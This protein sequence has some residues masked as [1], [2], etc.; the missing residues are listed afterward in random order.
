MGDLRVRGA[1]RMALAVFMKLAACNVKRALKYWGQQANN[2]VATGAMG[3]TARCSVCD[4]IDAVGAIANGTMPVMMLSRS[5]QSYQY[6]AAC[7]G[8]CCGE[9]FMRSIA[10]N[11][12]DSL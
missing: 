2:A 7:N 4:G 3:I 12:P 8:G 6:A 10:R 9:P 5:S 1:A 11:L